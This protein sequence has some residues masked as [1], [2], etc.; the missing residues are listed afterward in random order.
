MLLLSLASLTACDAEPGPDGEYD[1]G[2][3]INAGE[4]EVG[5][6]AVAA[7]P[8]TSEAGCHVGLPYDW[9]YCSNSCPCDAL[10]GDCDTNLQC[11]SGLQCNAD[12][13]SKFGASSTVDICQ[14]PCLVPPWLLRAWWS[15]DTNAN[16]SAG[17]KHG[18]LVGG[19]TA[20][21][22]GFAEGAFSFNGT[23]YVQVA[24]H[25]DMDFG[26]GDLSM[27]MWVK[28]ADQSGVKVLVDKRKETGTEVRGYVAYLASGQLGFQLGDR[29]GSWSCSSNAT[30]SCTNW[31]TGVDIADDKWHLVV[32]TV[33]RDSATGLRFY[34]DGSLASTKNPTL[35]SGSLSNDRPLRIGARSENGTGKFTGKIDEVQLYGRVLSAGEVENIYESGTNGLCR[36]GGGGDGGGDGGGQPPPPPPPSCLIAPCPV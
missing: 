24:D 28:T 1:G 32:I 6:D 33:D 3:D 13:G 18:S 2:F 15:G 26:T 30:S 21:A 9:S 29:A 27:A 5:I 4:P 12:L 25:G 19:T 23:G 20:G 10:E 16:D 8:E 17:S 14:A 22:S 34:V 36:T 11:V 31:S 35:R 7:S